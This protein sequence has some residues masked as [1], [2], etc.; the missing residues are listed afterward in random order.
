MNDGAQMEFFGCQYG[1]PFLKIKTHLPA[2]NRARTCPGP[3][4]FYVALIKHM[5]HQVEV[6]L[7]TETRYLV[8]ELF[9]R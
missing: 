2:E 1:K 9:L 7:H 5:L 4:G 3:V 8:F 6:S